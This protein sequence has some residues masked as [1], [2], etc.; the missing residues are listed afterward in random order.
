MNEIEDRYN[1]TPKNT[2]SVRRRLTGT[3]SLS[4]RE[5]RLDALLLLLLLLHFWPRYDTYWCECKENYDNYLGR[6]RVEAFETGEKQNDS[7]RLRRYSPLPIR[8]V[9]TKIGI[10]DGYGGSQLM[11]MK[12]RH[13]DN[14]SHRWSSVCFR[15]RRVLLRHTITS[16]RTTERGEGEEVHK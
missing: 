1:A 3:M 15:R 7:V 13:E 2:L 16:F 4:A 5:K 14:A 11:N 8:F 10:V 9:N 12:Q 6:S